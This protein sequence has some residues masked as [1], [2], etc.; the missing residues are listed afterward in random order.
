MRTVGYELILINDNSLLLIQQANF[1]SHSS[2]AGVSSMVAV[3]MLP[4]SCEVPDPK[5]F[6]RFGS[7]QV[8]KH[9]LDLNLKS[10]VQWSLHMSIKSHRGFRQKSLNVRYNAQTNL[11]V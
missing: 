9:H 6:A 5:P 8:K 3:S 2:G 1:F 11:N 4:N 10:L 7:G